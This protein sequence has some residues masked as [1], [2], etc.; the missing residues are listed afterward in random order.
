MLHNLDTIFGEFDTGSKFISCNEFGDGNINDTY[1]I[2]AGG[3]SDKKYFMQRIN[4]NVFTRPEDVMTNIIRVTEHIRIKLE[5]QGIEDI[6]RRV[7]RFYFCGNDGEYFHKDNNGNYWRLCKFIDGATAHN[8]YHNT[9]QAYEASKS[10]SKFISQLTDLPGEPLIDTI[11]NFLDGKPRYRQ[12]EEA[13]KKN[14]A[15][16]LPSVITEVK[17]IQDNRWIFDVISDLVNSG[18]LPVRITHN[19]TKIN[20]IMID[21][22]T[23]EGVCV[24]DL[25]TV[26]P[27]IVMYDIGDIIR[28]TLTSF[29]NDRNMELPDE[30]FRLDMIEAIIEGFID[31]G[32]DYLTKCETDHLLFGGMYMTYILACRFLTDYLNGD[33]YFKV[34]SNTHNILRCRNQIKL[35]EFLKNIK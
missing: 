33:T 2:H 24:I 25:D 23:S 6:N 26:M 31:G 14:I 11:P 34:C 1:L 8:E 18:E 21:D 17:Y 15:G 28:S 30:M 29:Y 10:V 13:V 3:S 7:M 5:D 12:F 19:D 22:Q 35:V 20:N 4:H 32:K 27:G 16:R 9:K